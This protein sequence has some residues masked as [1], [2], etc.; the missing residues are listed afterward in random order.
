[1]GNAEPR[2]GR[3]RGVPILFRGLRKETDPAGPAH[4]DHI[5]RREIKTHL[6]ELQDER[7]RAI[8]LDRPFS[9]P[10][11]TKKDLEECCLAARVR[12]QEREHRPLTYLRGVVPED[13]GRRHVGMP[14][15]TQ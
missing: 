12:P 13:P 7:Y 1:M 8:D 14:E 9:W 5:Q 11:H 4:E 2:H 10:E 6:E 3:A 15:I